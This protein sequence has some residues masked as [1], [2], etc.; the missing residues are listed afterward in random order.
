M[1]SIV[2]FPE[3]AEIVICGWNIEIQD[4]KAAN[5]GGLFWDIMAASRMPDCNRQSLSQFEKYNISFES[6][7]N[8]CAEELEENPETLADILFTHYKIRVIM[9]KDIY[10]RHNKFVSFSA[11]P[12][13]RY[14]ADQYAEKIRDC[15]SW[16]E[17][18][19]VAILTGVFQKKVRDTATRELEI[20]LKA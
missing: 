14:I 13:G 3:S 19:D 2:G 4:Q 15:D 8:Y 17:L 16:Q 9:H 6:V 10:D 18:Y 7:I 1:Q 11:S 12:A 20:W 5:E